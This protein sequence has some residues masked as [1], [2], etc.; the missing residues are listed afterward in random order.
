MLAAGLLLWG[1]DTGLLRDPAAAPLPAG[2]GA[3]AVGGGADAANQPGGDKPANAAGPP[4]PPPPPPAPGNP[5][6]AL[7]PFS[8][9]R[10]QFAFWL[11]L[12]TGGF[13]FIWLTTGQFLEW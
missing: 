5:A 2:N 6:A 4:D 7:P 8:L 10:T 3:N 11:F 13:L 1:W 9:A 12:V